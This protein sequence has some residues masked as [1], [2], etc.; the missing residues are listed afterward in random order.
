MTGEAEEGKP[1]GPGPAAA[2][3]ESLRICSEHGFAVKNYDGYV[4]FN[5]LLCKGLF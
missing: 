1:F 4:M 2:L 3:E 5:E